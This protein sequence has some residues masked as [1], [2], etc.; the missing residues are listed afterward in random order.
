VSPLSA[1]SSAT[2]LVVG[3]EHIGRRV[4]LHLL[5]LG[6]QPLFFV[7]DERVEDKAWLKAHG[8][9]FSI[10][11]KMGDSDEM[12]DK[13]VAAKAVLLLDEDD[14]SNI[15]LILDIRK[16]Q[17]TLSIVARIF[18]QTLSD[19][20]EEKFQVRCLSVSSIAAPVFAAAA[21]GEDI[22]GCFSTHNQLVVAATRS[23]SEQIDQFLN[24]SGCL[25]IDSQT[26]GSHEKLFLLR[27]RDWSALQGERGTSNN[28]GHWRK[29]S[30]HWF[31]LW[32]RRVRPMVKLLLACFL[33]SLIIAV[34]VFH[35]GMGLSL[36]DAYYLAITIV[37]TVGFGDIN[38]LNE[39]PAV[40]VFGTFLMLVGAGLL[41]GLFS[42]FTELLVTARLKELFGKEFR[43]FENHIIVVGFGNVGYRV[44][45][46]LST[47]G[48][49]V[50][51]IDQKN[52]ASWVG[53]C[54]EWLKF[55][56]TESRKRSLRARGF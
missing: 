56:G 10:R 2:V 7:S 35:R 14:L 16:H 43:S 4:A 39:T 45:K 29:A 21:H 8:I 32:W 51:V 30:L 13:L 20:L 5:R 6:L 17:P 24:L 25:C 22:V 28:G 40:K 47:N 33:V 50:V 34:I 42:I 12:K 15:K 1:F 52:Q 11:N 55:R 38:L 46:E 26:K 53:N 31:V 9:Q 48:E 23:S 18:D 41:A 54:R 36:L 49:H 27:N 37:T 44:A 19:H 3:V